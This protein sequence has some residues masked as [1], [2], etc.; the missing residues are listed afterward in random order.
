ML[1]TKAVQNRCTDAS[2]GLGTRNNGNSGDEEAEAEHYESWGHEWSEDDDEETQRR[3]RLRGGRGGGGEGGMSRSGEN[4]D[5][6]GGMMM[7]SPTSNWW[8]R[9]GVVYQIAPACFCDSNGDGWGDIMG[10]VKNMDYIHRLGVS[11][12]Y[13]NPIYES[14]FYDFGYDITDFG[15]VNPRFGTKKDVELLCESAHSRGIA[16]VL[17]WVPNHTSASHKWFQQSKSSRKNPFRDW[18]IWADP[19]P[20][21]GPPNNWIPSFGTAK[22]SWTFDSGTGQYYMHSFTPEQPDLN[23]RC[24][25]LVHA[26]HALMHD[27]MDLGIDGFRLDAI[28]FLVKDDQLQD[29]PINPDWKPGM[30]STSRL[31]HT[32]TENLPQVHDVIKGFRRVVASHGWDKVL[33]GELWYPIETAISFYGDETE[34]Y[35]TERYDYDECDL[36]MNMSLVDSVVNPEHVEATIEEYIAG[37]LELKKRSGPKWPTPAP[38]WTIGCHDRSRI[39]SR[40]GPNVAAVTMLELTLPGTCFI[41][42]GDELGLQDGDFPDSMIKDPAWLAE[43]GVYYCR[44]RGRTP[45]PWVG[46]MPQA[47]FTT[48]T[49]WIPLRSDWKTCNAEAQLKDPGSLLNLCINLIHLRRT[50]P[51]TFSSAT[52]INIIHP[53]LTP[54]SKGFIAYTLSSCAESDH[55]SSPE[56][57][58]ATVT[59][60]HQ[61]AVFINLSNDT[62][63]ASWFPHNPEYNR[64]HHSFGVELLS[65]SV[66]TPAT[67]QDHLPTPPPPHHSPVQKHRHHYSCCIN[68]NGTGGTAAIIPGDSNPTATTSS[69]DSAASYDELCGDHVTLHPHTGTVIACSRGDTPYYDGFIPNAIFPYFGFYLVS[70]IESKRYVFHKNNKQL[71]EK[72]NT[73]IHT[74][75]IC[76]EC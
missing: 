65:T 44:D 43:P 36:P 1:A 71:R 74:R 47:G 45:F 6:E 9:G 34:D 66:P 32:G 61:L 38:N 51:T 28:G 33:M 24:Q 63:T 4:E 21:G 15:Q 19:S 73:L 50:F 12:I 59:Q 41:Y 29:E 75:A 42:N 35:I 39:A 49:P 60:V 10:I 64:N 16:V 3:L 11:C 48:G 67:S 8:R 25:G 70:V 22:S 55:I 31:L 40:V 68:A 62:I 69:T 7:P 26:M 20:T 2:L 14:P 57:A 53:A 72:I 58:P 56:S 52:C 76:G 18:Y 54:P 23:W 27:W 46:N 30:I 13:L 17:D 5:E 37:I